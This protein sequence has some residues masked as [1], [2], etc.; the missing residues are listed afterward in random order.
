VA[1][2]PRGTAPEVWSTTSTPAPFDVIASATLSLK[3]PANYHGYKGRSHSLRYADAQAKKRRRTAENERKTAEAEA[4]AEA[5][6]RRAAAERAEADRLEAES[7]RQRRRKKAVKAE[8]GRAAA[9]CR[10]AVVVRVEV[11]LPLAARV[12]GEGR[13]RCSLSRAWS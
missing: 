13:P 5:K 8:A 12:G 11:D 4:A 1:R 3:I 6:R 10:S 2:K 7:V 9:G